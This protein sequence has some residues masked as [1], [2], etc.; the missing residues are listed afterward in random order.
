MDERAQAALDALLSTRNLRDVCPETVRR[1]FTE[2]LPRYRKPKDAEKAAQAYVALCRFRTA[3]ERYP[4]T[5]TAAMVVSQCDKLVDHKYLEGRVL[6]NK[7][8]Q[9]D[10]K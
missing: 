5:R 7:R 3:V 9:S 6:Y 2:L 10:Y 4:E 8:T 1:V